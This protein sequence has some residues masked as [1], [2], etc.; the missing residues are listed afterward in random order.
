[1]L[2]EYDSLR[3]ESLASIG[4]RISIMNFTFGA[5]SVL[6]AALV[7]SAIPATVGAVVSL[8]VLPQIA[9]AALIIWLGEYGRS[10]R[11]GRGIASLEARINA[12]LGT[13]A[14][15]WETSL[16]S[17]STHMSYPYVATVLLILGSGYAAELLG[18][19]FVTEAMAAFGNALFLAVGVVAAVILLWE[20]TFW[21]YFR[22]R[23]V[24]IRRG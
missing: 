16:L 1:M 11:A 2:A 4:H 15:S 18:L 6:L 22:S 24:E 13:D 3:S 14:I 9:K 10:Q 23:W 8:V 19:W 7:A 20:A 5:L 17:Q 12:L 21:R